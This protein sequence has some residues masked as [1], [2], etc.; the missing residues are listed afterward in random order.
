MF[1]TVLTWFLVGFVFTGFCLMYW[2]I[3]TNVSPLS[4]L[5]AILI[6]CAA[7]V[8]GALV[9]AIVNLHKRY[10][11][12]VKF[13]QY[14]LT[15]SDMQKFVDSTLQV[16]AVSCDLSSKDLIALQRHGLEGIREAG[17]DFD[18]AYMI[19][20]YNLKA[21]IDRFNKVYDAAT[22]ACLI[23][24]RWWR[25]ELKGRDFKEYLPVAP[26]VHQLLNQTKGRRSSC[27]HPHHHTPCSFVY[28]RPACNAH[29][30]LF[31]LPKLIQPIQGRSLDRSG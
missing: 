22:A 30:G 5:N 18:H 17:A 20:S 9:G 8:I 15:L 11:K 31:L 23:A 28:K 3:I 27:L 29:A 14:F 12:V 13:R 10:Q 4:D 26:L 6:T 1:Q 2:D 19:R 7:G 21:A 16:L 24:D 25:T